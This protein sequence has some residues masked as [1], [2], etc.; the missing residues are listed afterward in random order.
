MEQTGS[1]RRRVL[2]DSEKRAYVQR[3]ARSGKTLAVFCRD[4]G[5]ALSSFQSWKRKFADKSAFIEIAAPRR[6]HPVSVEVGLASGIK[7]VT[8]PDCDPS[9]LAKLVQALGEA[10]C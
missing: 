8:T 10:S 9:W 3:Q 6:T 4:E 1:R 2:S 5:I 7:V